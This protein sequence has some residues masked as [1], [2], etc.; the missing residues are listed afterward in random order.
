MC[1]QC[2]WDISTS[3]LLLLCTNRKVWKCLVFVWNTFLHISTFSHKYF[4][5][6]WKIKHSSFYFYLR[7]YLFI[8]ICKTGISKYAF[9]LNIRKWYLF[10]IKLHLVNKR[11]GF[12]YLKIAQLLIERIHLGS[13]CERLF[14]SK[15]P[16]LEKDS[17]CVCFKLWGVKMLFISAYMRQNSSDVYS[18]KNKLFLFS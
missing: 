7:H 6:H 11:L 16:Y 18:L 15:S 5:T 1:F 3:E 10:T 17:V 2:K 9:Y 4:S 12:F 14:L 8:S 13:Y